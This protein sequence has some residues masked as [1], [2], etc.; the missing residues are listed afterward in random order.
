MP[1]MVM[2]RDYDVIVHNVT[3]IMEVDAGF[4]KV[5][6]RGRET[7]NYTNLHGLRSGGLWRDFHERQPSV[8]VSMVLLHR[9]VC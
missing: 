5:C 2:A 4:Q 6:W 9:D 3:R 7:N 1:Y 8:F